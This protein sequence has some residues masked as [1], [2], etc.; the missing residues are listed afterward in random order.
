V[1]FSLRTALLQPDRWLFGGVLGILVWLPW[2]WGS[3][4]PAAMAFL[5]VCSMSLFLGWLGM[6]ALGRMELPPISLAVRI[7]LGLWLAWLGWIVLQLLP[8]PGAVLELVSPRAAQA[9][10]AVAA[11]GGEA[12]GSLSISPGATWAHTLLTLSYFALYWLVW[13]TVSSRRRLRALLLVIAVTGL[14]QALYGIFTALSGLEWGLFGQKVHSGQLASGSFVNRNHFAAYME[15]GLA[16]ALALILSELDT[17]QRGRPW[18]QV[19]VGLLELALSAKL[20]IRVFAAVMVIALVLS[21]SR[22][23]NVGFFVSL[24]ICGSLFVLLRHRRWLIPG[25]VLFTSLFLIDLLIVSRWFGLERVVE[26]LEQTTA[27][28]LPH[29]D[30]AIILQDLVPAAKAYA[31]TGS[32]LGTFRY[33]YTPFRADALSRSYFEHAHNEP[34]QIL[35]EAGVIGLGLLGAWVLLHWIYSLRILLRRQDR[36]YTAAAFGG[37]MALTSLLLHSIAEFHLRMPA[38]AATLIAL[39]GLLLTIPDRSRQTE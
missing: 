31:A 20:R 6:L 32:G 35:I 23:G 3:I 34:A 29:D 9:H 26:R 10:G 33:A 5:G 13:G 28:T 17:W 16:A 39:M 25:L 4:T 36:L 18:R 37:L 24:G 27:E 30:R 19:A 22:M 15:L 8:L 38:V 14:L 12:L 11:V 7:S 21:Q 2:P 1:S